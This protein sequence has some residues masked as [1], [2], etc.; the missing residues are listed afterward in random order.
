M[1]DGG[2]RRLE[3]ELVQGKERGG[4]EGQRLVEEGW[5]VGRVGGRGV[6]LWRV[7]CGGLQGGKTECISRLNFRIT[8][9]R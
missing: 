7:G 9:M 1:E 5:G 8:I 2:G 6:E 4:V 3:R